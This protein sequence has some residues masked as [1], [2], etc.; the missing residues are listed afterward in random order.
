MPGRTWH[1][2]AVLVH[3]PL[4]AGVSATLMTLGA[5]G[6][7]EDH[8]PGF[9]PRYRQP[10]DKGP[11]PRA[12]R[13]VLLRAW[14][15]DLPDAATFDTGLAG[16]AMEAPVWGTEAEQ[17]WAE[18]WKVHFT[19]VHITDRLVVAAPWHGVPGALL[20]EPGNAFGTG[21]HVTTRSCLRAIDRLAR[22]GGTLL[23][24]GC[25]SGI[26]ALAGAR[27]GMQVTGIDTDPDAVR[28]A[29]EA[30][31]LNGLDATFSTTP[32]EHLLGPYDLVVANLYAEVLAH[33][34]PHLL[35]LAAGPIACAGI[36]ADRADLVR[37]A[38]G[39]RTVVADHTEDGWTS[40]V[41]GAP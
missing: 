11:P 3:R 26:L 40:L 19:P 27:L 36:L 34:G 13:H 2:V 14:F 18:G 25:G 4:A 29:Q 35:R 24:V 16:R 6:V 37:R 31:V 8:P 32:V 21:E 1:T 23:D 17:D 22:Q 30:A 5:T 10:W 41:F 33:L 39:S 12:A 38:L 15:A 28:A 20:I 9:T 7:Q